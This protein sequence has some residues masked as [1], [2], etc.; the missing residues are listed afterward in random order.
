MAYKIFYA[1][2]E[3]HFPYADYELQ[4]DDVKLQNALKSMGYAELDSF[5]DLN[6]ME[7]EKWTAAL[8]GYFIEEAQRN[9]FDR[10]HGFEGLD[11][12]G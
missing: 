9:A 11:Q 8:R 3:K 12:I 2:D 5:Y 6:P 10:L 7:K 1:Y 4:I